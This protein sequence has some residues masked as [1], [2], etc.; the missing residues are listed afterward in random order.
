[1][2]VNRNK[3]ELLAASKGMNSTQLATVAEI[4][5]QNLSTIKTR[6]TCAP[7]SAVKIAKALGVDVTEILVEVDKRG[8]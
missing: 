6:G 5:R 4:S 8:R 2:I 3:I 1:M 7:L